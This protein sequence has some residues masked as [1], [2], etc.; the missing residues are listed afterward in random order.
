MELSSCW[1]FSVFVAITL[2]ESDRFT[3]DDGLETKTFDLG[4][5][6]LNK[7]CQ[8]TFVFNEKFK[9]LVYII[10]DQIA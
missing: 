4:G 5:L 1:T 10:F 7:S 9:V 8:H 6:E 2:V 3:G